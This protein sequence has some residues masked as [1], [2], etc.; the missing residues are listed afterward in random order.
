MNASSSAPLVF[1]TVGG[2]SALIG[3]AHSTRL[4]D[5]DRKGLLG[6]G[7]NLG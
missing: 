5:K 6:L 7:L 3:L 4:L 1:D 2:Y